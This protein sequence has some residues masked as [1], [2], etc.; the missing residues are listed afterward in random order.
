MKKTALLMVFSLWLQMHYFDS[1]ANSVSK[2]FLLKI[3]HHKKCEI[4]ME[5]KRWILIILLEIT[6]NLFV[7]DDFKHMK[8]IRK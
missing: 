8:M 5:F 7:V 2:M 4:N 3:S 6:F 1:T